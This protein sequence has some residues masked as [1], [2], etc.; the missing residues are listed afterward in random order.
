MMEK[1]LSF[2]SDVLQVAAL[3]RDSVVQVYPEEVGPCHQSMMHL[4]VA[5]GGT[6]S[7]RE[8]SWVYGSGQ[9]RRG[10]P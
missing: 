2:T 7:N 10:F 6:A 8:G 3:S 4:Q 9:P 1:V 5:D